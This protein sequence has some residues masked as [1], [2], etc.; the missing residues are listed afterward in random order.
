MNIHVMGVLD[1]AYLHF[2]LRDSN[3]WVQSSHEN[4]VTCYFTLNAFCQDYNGSIPE[5]NELESPS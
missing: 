2:E 1:L 5:H 4:L 3:P